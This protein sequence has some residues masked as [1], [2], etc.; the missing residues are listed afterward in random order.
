M[1]TG[2]WSS[3]TLTEQSNAG[4]IEGIK[5]YLFSYNVNGWVGL[6]L[7]I[8]NWTSAQA[9]NFSGYDSLQLSYLGPIGPGNASI[10]LRDPSVSSGSVT[11]PSVSSYTTISIPLSSF[12]GADLS[13]IT[14]LNIS[15][16]SGSATFRIDNIRL[17]KVCPVA[18]AGINQSV[19]ASDQVNLDATVTNASSVS[20]TTGGTG[21]FSNNTLE[22][23]VYTPS[24]SDISAG[25]VT[26]TLMASESGC[27]NSSDQM[28]ININTCTINCPIV[29]AGIDQSVCAND[30]VNLAST[31]TDATSLSWTTGGTGN[32]T[33]NTLEDPIYTPSASDISTGTVTLTLTASKSGCTNSSD[34][35][36]ININT[37]TGISSSQS[38][39][40]M[41]MIYPNPATNYTEIKLSEGL[42]INE[43]SIYNILGEKV[44]LFTV[45][46]NK[47]SLPIDDLN[48][49]I[50]YLFLTEKSGTQY[51]RRI[52]KQ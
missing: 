27:T 50:Y 16:A 2:T 51:S 13:K 37:C 29:D 12:T 11:L 10:S 22:D 44:K 9:K 31:V 4:A 15:F 26:L 34:Q 25:T 39:D 7:N 40:N 14:E 32:F 3:G 36:E 52:I 1:I 30:Q 41:I 8:S 19:C 42:M 5:D 33:N 49:G 38:A 24:A 46:G 28:E 6:G 20:W 21:T 48:K 18:V 23:P 17:V 45:S 47:I 35:M 43:I